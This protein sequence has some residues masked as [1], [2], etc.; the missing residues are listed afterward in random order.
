M[1]VLFIYVHL[2]IKMWVKE[3]REYVLFICSAISLDF[4]LIQLI[5][6]IDWQITDRRK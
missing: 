1:I 5:T 6:Q 3:K 4:E 2:Q